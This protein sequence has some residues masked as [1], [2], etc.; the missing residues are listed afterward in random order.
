MKIRDIITERKNPVKRGNEHAKIVYDSQDA[1]DSFE[2]ADKGRA[3]T[4]F[5][6]MAALKKV[7][8]M[9]GVE[10]VDDFS[11]YNGLVDGERKTDEAESLLSK[12][13]R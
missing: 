2:A 5:D 1:R 9:Y 12:D 10:I 13:N 6:A 3:G 7:R 11:I 4:E 8:D